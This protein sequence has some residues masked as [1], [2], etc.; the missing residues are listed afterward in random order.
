[1]ET[2]DEDKGQDSPRAKGKDKA[3]YEDTDNGEHACKGKNRYKTQIKTTRKRKCK[4]RGTGK[5]NCKRKVERGEHEDR[6][7]REWQRT[8]TKGKMNVLLKMKVQGHAKTMVNI[9]SEG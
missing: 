9:Y 4:D 7:C 6:R 8:K 5:E 1:M 2:I 3:K